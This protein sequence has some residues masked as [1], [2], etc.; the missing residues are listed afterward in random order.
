MS[1]LG[2]SD[3]SLVTLYYTY[4]NAGDL[5]SAAAILTANPTLQTK[6]FNAA[7][8]NQ[9]IDALVAIETFF[10][11]DSY[12]YMGNYSATSAYAVGNIVYEP[13]YGCSYIRKNSGKTTI[14]ADNYTLDASGNYTNNAYAGTTL[15]FGDLYQI[16][17]DGNTVTTT[18]VTSGANVT[19]TGSDG[20][21]DVVV[22]T[23]TSLFMVDC[24]DL[25]SDSPAISIV[26]CTVSAPINSQ[27]STYWGLISI[28]G[29]KW[30]TGTA[31]TGVSTTP[32]V[33]SDTNIEYANVGDMYL[34][35]DTQHTYECVVGGAAATAT[36]KYSGSIFG[37]HW[38]TGTAITGTSTTPAVYSGSGIAYAHVNDMYFNT[39]TD[40][41]YEC[42]AEG[43]ASTAT[44]AYVS[45]IKGSTGASGTGL[46]PRGV[47]N[48]V[49]NYYIND[50]VS[51][52]NHLWQC[53]VDNSNSEPTLV[54]TNWFSILTY[55][56]ASVT[57]TTLYV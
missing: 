55:P 30:Y 56:G 18:A 47:W 51:H 7:K 24:V 10:I 44:W 52:D 25:A 14:A 12:V 34:N 48:N 3:L 50:C 41:V 11:G 46:A 42:K 27:T 6:I 13:D 4:Y 57:G 22:T 54:N 37:T 33:F 23:G 49:E 17:V 53:L 1:D 20:V 8:F 32:T 21:Y 29:S 15:A 28:G 38:Y 5:A 40:Y 16:T 39:S 31:I 19:L 36:W 2:A 26:H 45:C 9:L 43:N 35:T